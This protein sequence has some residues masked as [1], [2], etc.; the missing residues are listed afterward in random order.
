MATKRKYPNKH[1]RTVRRRIMEIVAAV[2]TGQGSLA[3]DMERVLFR[4]VLKRIE[5]GVDDPSG[6]AS[7]ALEVDYVLK[8]KTDGD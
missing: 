1:V 5:L 8:R 7:E 4:D 6:L 3:L 2:R